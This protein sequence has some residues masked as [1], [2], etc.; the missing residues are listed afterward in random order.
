MMRMTMI[1]YQT[2]PLRSIK[3][4]WLRNRASNSNISGT[5]LIK[6]LCVVVSLKEITIQTT[7]T[8]N[9]S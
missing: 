8:N 5:F 1:S 2:T 9:P 6:N 3:E 7:R 4:K